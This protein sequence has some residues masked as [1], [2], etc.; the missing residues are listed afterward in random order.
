MSA[1]ATAPDS[2]PTAAPAGIGAGPWDAPGP[3]PSEDY[4]AIAHLGPEELEA[5]MLRGTTPDLDA[6]VGWEH[7][8]LNLSWWQRRS[9]IEKFVKGLYRKPDGTVWGYNLPV[10]QD[11]VGRPWRAKPSDEAPKRFGFYRVSPVDSTAKDNLYL[12]ALLLDYGRGPNPR[13]DPSRT[14]R[15]YLVQ[16]R[17]DRPDLLLGKAYLALGPARPAVG[18]FLLERRRRTDYVGP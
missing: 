15:D 11:G 8:G 9:P 16:V 3:L 7:R 4:R 2:A 13:L 5:L 14:I 1:Q 18:F 12:R 17:P 10:V 6:L